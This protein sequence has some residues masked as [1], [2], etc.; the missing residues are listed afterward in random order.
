MKIEISKYK[1]KWGHT[2][3]ERNSEVVSSNFGYKT[4]EEAQK[5]HGRR[6]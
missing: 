6:R 5:R 3:F 2:I 4:K 1:N